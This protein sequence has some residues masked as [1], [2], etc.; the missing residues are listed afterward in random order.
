MLHGMQTI[1]FGPISELSDGRG[2][3]ADQSAPANDRRPDGQLNRQS[4]I[5]NPI[6]GSKPWH[7]AGGGRKK[8]EDASAHD[9]LSVDLQP[10]FWHGCEVRSGLLSLK[11]TG[12]CILHALAAA[13]F[14]SPQ[15]PA[16]QMR[17]Q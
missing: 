8:L 6:K 12:V 2:I 13:R 15:L 4:E 7:A 3:D 16:T 9:D 17:P 1:S 14:F 10:N 11:D 5:S